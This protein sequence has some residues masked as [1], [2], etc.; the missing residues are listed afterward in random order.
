MAVNPTD[1]SL[2]A[3][4]RKLGSP[5]YEQ[6]RQG[7]RE[8]ILTNFKD[9]DRFFT[10]RELIARLKVSQPTV[11]RAMAELVNEGTLVRGVGKGTFVRKRTKEL[12]V[13]VIT[14]DV[15]SSVIFSSIRTISASCAR[16]DYSL[17]LYYLRHGQ[18]IPDF[19]KSLHRAPL[20]ERFIIHGA[21]IEES[22][23]IYNE[24][25]SRGYRTV[26]LGGPIPG[27]PGNSVQEDVTEGVHIA[28]NHLLSLNHRRILFLI[29]EPKEIATISRRLVSIQEF[30][31]EKNLT[32]ARIVDCNLPVWQNSFA[33]AYGKMAE[34]WAANP[35][36]TAIC[37]VSGAGTWGVLR[38]LTE[39]Q[40][41]VPDEVS[42]FS[43]D[44]LPGG[45]M[46]YPSLTALASHPEQV[47]TAMDILWSDN[48][49]PQ[50]VSIPL[51][52]AAR[53]STGPVPPSAA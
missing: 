11:R 37:P 41:R 33:A 12:S 13:G 30:I 24:L 46:V 17:H 29:N 42:L 25:D 18:S 4:T 2:N 7:L 52:L 16:R 5:L 27:Y 34:I 15:D 20:E 9:G 36:P 31:R 28:I 38:F 6:V 1:I 45:E 21:S 53:E 22:W 23:A 8:L 51:K 49:H 35:R 44:D 32:E 40:I 47:E 50:L 14:P 48:P 43:F 10:E 19:C 26:L 39:R 3:V